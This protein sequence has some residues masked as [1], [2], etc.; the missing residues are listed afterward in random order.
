MVEFKKFALI[1]LKVVFMIFMII[2]MIMWIVLTTQEVRDI[3]KVEKRDKQQHFNTYDWRA[4]ARVRTI[5]IVN[6]ILDE[7][8]ALM[9]IIGLFMNKRF[10]LSTSVIILAIIWFVAQY[11]SNALNVQY[12][13]GNAMLM[14]MSQGNGLLMVS[15]ILHFIMICVGL[16]FAYFISEETAKSGKNTKVSANNAASG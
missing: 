2:L 14:V 3:N 1:S 5:T 15:H 4:Y 7:F 8:L 13:S 6:V 11:G 16:V 9:A 10:I 12:W